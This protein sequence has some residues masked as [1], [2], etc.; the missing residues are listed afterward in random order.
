MKEVL[1]KRMQT[2]DRYKPKTLE[3][4][5]QVLEDIEAIKEVMHH[6]S[7]CADIGDADGMIACFSDDS[8][9]VFILENE[10][11][12]REEYCFTKQDTYDFYKRALRAVESSS[13][14]VSNE[15]ILFETKDMAI[16]YLYLYSWQR[17]KAQVNKLDLHRWGRYEIRYV[18]EEDNEWRIKNL[19]LLAAGEHNGERI[20]EQFKRPWPPEPL[21]E[22]AKS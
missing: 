19:R 13:H 7:R 16:G 8:T 21:L 1:N 14:H 2:L 6:Y 22:R 3:E 5:I 11:G 4:R 9:T 17:F 20:S 15:Q 12:K 10:E 18:R